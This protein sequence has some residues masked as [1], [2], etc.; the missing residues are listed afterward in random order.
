MTI[1]E[2]EEFEKHSNKHIMCN[3]PMVR[4]YAPRR[5]V[6]FHEDVYENIGQEPLHISNAQQLQDACRQNDVSSDYMRDFGASLFRVK[7][8]RW[9]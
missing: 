2:M 9:I 7:E 8:G 3:A 4:I 6:K 1:A 5:H